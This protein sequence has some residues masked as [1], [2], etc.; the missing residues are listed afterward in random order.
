[1][2][3][4]S[5]SGSLAG[6]H[7]GPGSAAGSACTVTPGPGPSLSQAAGWLWRQWPK[8]LLTQSLVSPATRCGL[9][10]GRRRQLEGVRPDA[11]MSVRRRQVRTAHL[12]SQCPASGA[13][14]HGALGLGYHKF[15]GGFPRRVEAPLSLPPSLPS[16]PPSLP[17]SLLPV[18]SPA[19]TNCKHWFKVHSHRR[20][21]R[22]AN[23]Q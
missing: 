16:L 1:M 23:A 9:R 21:R 10:V 15:S 6:S 5:A 20:A 22:S 4:A 13:A 7:S 17:P 14:R 18:N 3:T 12:S 8:L 11:A 19:L 2:A